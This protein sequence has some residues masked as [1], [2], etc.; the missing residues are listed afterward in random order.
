[1]VGSQPHTGFPE[2]IARKRQLGI[3]IIILCCG[4]IA[5][6][7]AQ[8]QTKGSVSGASAP[9]SRSGLIHIGETR[10]LIPDVEVFNEEGREVRF[11][12]DLVK[13]KIVLL[14]FFY[15]SCTYICEM[16]GEN[17]SRLRDQLGSRLGKDVFLVS[18]SMDP[19]TDTPE[20]LKHWARV[21]GVRSGWS[22]VSSNNAA[23]SG[24]L[25]ILTGEN[26]GQK[27]MHSSAVFIGNDRTGAWVSING[28]TEPEK[29]IDLFDEL[30]K[31][32]HPKR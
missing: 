12:T 8:V 21:F 24:M 31:N 9:T 4:L 30:D 17:L 16:Q 32:A 11:Y 29:L 18:V 25:K 1:M 15:T 28:L 7:S 14:N 6:A 2:T 20:K 27:E 3:S 23:M 13:D 10:A 26:P 22:L 5:Q 19:E